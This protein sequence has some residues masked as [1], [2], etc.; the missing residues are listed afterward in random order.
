MLQ[1]ETPI[2]KINAQF[3]VKAGVH[4]FMKRDDLIHP[5]I[6]GNKWRKLKYNILSFKKGEKACIIT[7]GGAYSNHLIATAAACAMNG[8]PSVG[9][10]RGDELN[11][12]SNFVLR[13]CEEY[14]MRLEFVSRSHYKEKSELIKNYY[15]LNGHVIP[16][17]GANDEGRRGCGEILSNYDRFDHVV[18][19]VGTATTMTGLIQGSKGVSHIHGIAALVNA[20]YL[21]DEVR[22]HTKLNNW[23]LHKDYSYGGFG[24]LSAQQIEF[25]KTFTTETGILLDPIYTGKMMRALV[26]LVKN[27]VIQKGQKVLCVH[28]GGF[29]GLLSEK[30]L[31]L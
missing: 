2:Q 6:S 14:G 4:V 17:G 9:I 18:V 21:E 7:F 22:R 31:T 15:Q 12:T 30:W 27:G 25:N 3:F 11:P 13:L 23:T 20:L 29:T 19:P 10:V 8:I 1:T 28:T 5:F 26:E 24:S 16:E